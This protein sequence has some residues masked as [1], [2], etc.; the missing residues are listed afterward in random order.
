MCV[1]G[2]LCEPAELRVIFVFAHKDTAL[3]NAPNGAEQL[4]L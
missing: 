4:L 1:R 3:L 2:D